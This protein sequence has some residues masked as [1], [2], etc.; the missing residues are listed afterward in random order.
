[1]KRGDLVLQKE[2]RGK[3][4]KTAKILSQLTHICVLPTPS[5]LGRLKTVQKETKKGRGT[6][7][8]R[9]GKDLFRSCLQASRKQ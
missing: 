7:G 8:R 3:E 2:K 5:I 4:K 6:L 1:M 9:K